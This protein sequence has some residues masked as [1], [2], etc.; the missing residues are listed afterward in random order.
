[1]FSK[2]WARAAEVVVLLVA[3][4]S[5]AG[6]CTPGV[7]TERGVRNAPS[8]GAGP[9]ADGRPRRIAIDHDDFAAKHVGHTTDGR[10]FFLT[11]PFVPGEY[12][13]DTSREFVALYLFDPDGHFLGAEIDALG[14]RERLQDR[15][16][17]RAYQA[18][19]TQLGKVTLDR[20]EIEPFAVERHGVQ[21]GLV[22]HEPQGP[23][24]M[25]WVTAEPGDYMA[26]SEPWDSGIYDT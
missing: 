5:L 22:A 7:F 13:T 16:A 6:G 3:G 9:A 19:L 24:D 4:A 20:I 15:E 25:W 10:Q 14:S 18:R 11:T 2:S 8:A 1:M 23:D 26:F 12:G 17:E 21:F